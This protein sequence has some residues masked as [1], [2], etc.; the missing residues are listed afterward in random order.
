ME[1][2]RQRNV[3]G[4]NPPSLLALLD[5]DSIKESTDPRDQIYAML[6]ISDT[7][8]EPELL[9]NYGQDIQQTYGRVCRWFL[10]QTPEGPRFLNLVGL[11][12]SQP[13]LPSWVPDFSTA[14]ALGTL[15][16]RGFSYNAGGDG[17][18]KWHVTE[19]LR[20]LIARGEI[21]D[22]VNECLEDSRAGLW[23]KGWNAS[24]E[25]I[26]LKWDIALRWFIESFRMTQRS[27]G[28]LSDSEI[29][30]RHTSTIFFNADP[31]KKFKKLHNVMNTYLVVANNFEYVNDV[32][33]EQIQQAMEVIFFA[34]SEGMG[35]KYCLTENGRVGQIPAES[36]P[37]DKVC[38]FP[39]IQTPFM[40]RDHETDGGS[41]RLIG[42][43]F[44]CGLMYGEVL[45]HKDFHVQEIRL[46]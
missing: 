41:F 22:V 5:R 2:L 25:D 38:V 33:D 14:K 42:E 13:Q 39:G 1:A 43:C 30:A 17:G 21:V 16:N 11:P 7:S 6:G 44:I 12:R 31:G 29:M 45:N 26:A 23:A 20:T 18:V 10:S 15:R 32:K 24:D 40:I 36:R 35:W 46:V 37:G 19:D 34:A 9:P 3:E 28:D 27:G 8:D 4:R